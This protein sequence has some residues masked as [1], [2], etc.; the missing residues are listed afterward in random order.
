M[1][2]G[3]DE[4][5]ASLARAFKKQKRHWYV[6]GA[7]A[8][9]AW[10]VP[11]ATADVDVTAAFDE[12]DL[13]PLLK[14]LG[15]AGFA[16]R[17]Q[18]L[19][20]EFRRSRVVPLLHR[21]SRTPIDLIAAGSGLEKEFLARSVPLKIGRTRVPVISLEDLILTKLLAARPKD[22]EDVRQLIAL[23]N[24]D[25][26]RVRLLLE[27]VEEAVDSHHLVPAFDRLLNDATRRR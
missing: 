4:V 21:R 9:V 1:A 27:S 25:T 22:V 3:I 14:T 8:V 16:I 5:L 18:A 23:G 13:A 11:R 2:D 17:D 7:Q 6:F 26:K 12:S 19:L 10:G 24:V 20:S 15:A